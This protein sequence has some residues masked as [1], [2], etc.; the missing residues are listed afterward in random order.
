[1]RQFKPTRGRRDGSQNYQSSLAQVLQKE[2]STDISEECT[3][4]KGASTHSAQ[5]STGAA[6]N[7]K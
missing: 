6:Q 1:V 4:I 2:Y 5:Q 7:Q 3:A